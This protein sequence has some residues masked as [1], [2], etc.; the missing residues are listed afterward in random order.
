VEWNLT[1]VG[2]ERHVQNVKVQLVSM[3][4]GDAKFKYTGPLENR[5]KVLGFNRMNQ[6]LAEAG[7]SQSVFAEA[8]FL[9]TLTYSFYGVLSKVQFYI[10]PKSARKEYA[11]VL[12]R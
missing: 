3:Q 6:M 4:N 10:A 8:P 9:S 2:Q 5:V 1:D 11:F 12:T 7:T